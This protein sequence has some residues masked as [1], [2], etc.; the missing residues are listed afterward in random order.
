MLLKKS[1]NT[2]SIT[3]PSKKYMEEIGGKCP[4]YWTY[5]GTDSENKVVCK[6][7]YNIPIHPVNA[8]NADISSKCLDHYVDNPEEN[9]IKRFSN[10]SSWPPKGEPLY[11]RCRWINSCGPK[12]K[13]NGSWLGMDKICAESGDIPP[14]PSEEEEHHQE[15]E[16][17]H[18]PNCA[19]YTPDDPYSCS[20]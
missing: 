17:H 7:N 11:E 19:S 3:Y 1:N 2:K 13:M 20:I 5:M 16:E 6:N 4:D 8:H 10:Y 9:N 15:E 14:V 18:D 12:V